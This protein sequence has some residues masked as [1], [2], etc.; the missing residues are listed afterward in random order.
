MAGKLPKT[1]LERSFRLMKSSIKVI[2]REVVAKLTAEDGSGQEAATLRFMAQARE[3]VGTLGD[4][5]GAAMKLGQLLSLELSDLLP[6]EVNAILRELHDSVPALNRGD[7]E[8][9]LLREFGSTRFKLIENLS[10]IPIGAASIG[11]VHSARIDGRDVVLKIQYPGVANS[12]DA[13]MKVLKTMVKSLLKL[14]Q[15]DIDVDPLFAALIE[16]LRNETDYRKEAKNLLAYR[17]TVGS[18]PMFLIPEPLVDWCTAHVLTMERMSGEPLSDWLRA[19]SD[20]RSRVWL[21]ETAVRLFVS[22]FVRYG[23]V[24]SDPN[25]GNFLVNSAEQKLVL[26]DCG[27]LHHYEPAFRSEYRALVKA[28]M[29]SERDRVRHLATA[30]KLID[31]R[32]ERRVQDQCVDLIILYGS[33]YDPDKQPVLF[34]DQ[35]FLSRLREETKNYATQVRYSA[36]P[37]QILFLNR[38]V[39]GIFHLL[40]ELAVGVNLANLWQEV[41]AVEL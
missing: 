11:Q 5:K 24:Q 6:P 20:R 12:I 15:K 31:P 40:K 37:Q 19:H 30:L 25:F 16:S 4:M 8:R 39:G 27:A 18:N 3:I 17:D 41:E 10:D 9:I 38:K 22:E 32:E 13:D 36:P 28:A 26:L 35:E 14:G 7:I 33:F 29:H 21:A 34:S 2:G 1:A 23:V